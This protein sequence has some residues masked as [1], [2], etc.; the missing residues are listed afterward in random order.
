[1]KH[2]SNATASN[3]LLYKAG[4]YAARLDQAG[5][6]QDLWGRH[7][8]TAFGAPYMRYITRTL[9]HTGKG[10]VQPYTSGELLLQST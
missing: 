8:D 6:L 2:M 4:M 3:S 5:V 10:N 7:S 9:C 1:M